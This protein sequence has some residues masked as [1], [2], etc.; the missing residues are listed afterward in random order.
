MDYLHE[1]DYWEDLRAFQKLDIKPKKP[2]VK[3]RMLSAEAARE[4]ID[5]HNPEYSFYNL[6]VYIINKNIRIKY[7]AAKEALEEKLRGLRVR[8]VL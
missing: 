7:A 1:K 8:P 6:F 3:F 2:N 5:A 4:F